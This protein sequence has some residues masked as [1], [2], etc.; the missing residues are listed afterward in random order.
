MNSPDLF[1]QRLAAEMERRGITQA[2]LA[3][4]ADTTQSNVSRVLNGQQA[5]LTLDYAERLAKAAGVELWKLLKPA[6]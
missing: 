3:A 4:D 6:R 2:T 5:T 1:R